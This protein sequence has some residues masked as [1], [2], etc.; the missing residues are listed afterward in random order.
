MDLSQLS[1]DVLV[2]MF[3]DNSSWLIRLGDRGVPFIT[4]LGRTKRYP[5]V[6]VTIELE[7]RLRLASEFLRYKAKQAVVT[8][9]DDFETIF[10]R[11]YSLLEF[12]H[13]HHDFLFIFVPTY[14]EIAINSPIPY[15]A[16]FDDK[17]GLYRFNDKG[18]ILVDHHNHIVFVGYPTPSKD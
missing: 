9:P 8:L 12:H 10:D 17:T 6:M 16:Y 2:S 14:E 18:G 11:A 15:K 4:D 1:N 7:H 3:N 13:A 5:L